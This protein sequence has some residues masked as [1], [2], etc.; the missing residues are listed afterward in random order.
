M[1]QEPK[2]Q[3]PLSEKVKNIP[4]VFGIHFTEKPKYKLLKHEG[5]FELREYEPMIVAK[6]T[7]QGSYEE[8]RAEAF[9]K[10]AN[11][12]FGENRE[13]KVMPMT[14]P[15]LQEGADVEMA[16][17]AMEPNVLQEFPFA[18]NKSLTMSFVLPSDIS[19]KIAP[20]P[21]D[22]GIHIEAIPSQTWAVVTY[23]G[24]NTPQDMRINYLKLQVW[25]ELR[26]Q[27]NESPTMRMAE[28]DGPNTISFLRKNEVQILIWSADL[29]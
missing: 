10:L 2:V 5:D 25:L 17:H 3:L 19:A 11:Y 28:Y 29:Q 9:K 16:I 26:G 23:S 15:V 20:L 13:H 6:V 4:G 1:E 8:A 24:E 7:V 18:G 12:I 22:S 21:T 27:K 14:A